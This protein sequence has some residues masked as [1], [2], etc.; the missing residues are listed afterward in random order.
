MRK[1]LI[2]V[3]MEP[4]HIQRLL[5]ICPDADIS[6]VSGKELTREQV[7]GAE[8]II[9][10]VPPALI[11]GSENLKWIQLN[12]AG[13]DGYTAPGVLP[14]GT[15]LTNA[16]GAYGLAISEHML[17]VTLQLMKKLNLYQREQEKH[18]WTDFGSVNS[19]EGSKTVV[20]GLGN[21]GGDYARKM[22]ALGSRV[23]GIR[24]SVFDKP[25]YLEKLCPLEQLKD[26]LKDA[27][28]VAA[29]LPGT[30]D[31]YHLFDK[32]MFAAMKEGAIFL[33][34]G[35]GTAVDQDALKE[36][37]DSGHLFGAGIDVTDPEPLPSEHP[38]WT[39]RNLL[40][41]PHVSGSYHLRETLERI[42]R[43]SED[44]LSRY[45]KGEELNNVVDFSTGYRDNKRYE[46]E[47]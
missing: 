6:L 44:N 30:K 16:T 42:I 41:T 45:L 4:E 40:I 9:G 33:N 25:D 46:A 19:I 17:G 3:P 2:T 26:C 13:T 39:A 38:L 20:V 31:T 28:I 36:A 10:N 23:T 32:E 1:I 14:E 8:I 18:A 29:A 22:N 34:V 15:I 35:R 7:Q 24:R 12:S 27:D 43:I 37:L 5:E 21:I 47:N 11:K